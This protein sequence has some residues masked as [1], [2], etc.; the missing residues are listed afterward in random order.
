[1]S[2]PST[3]S[4]E[5]YLDKLGGV[6]KNWKKRFFVCEKYLLHYYKD[7]EVGNWTSTGCPLLLL[8]LD[9]HAWM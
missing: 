9:V 7:K 1:M 6:R 4:K 2:T 3:S 5:G 8:L